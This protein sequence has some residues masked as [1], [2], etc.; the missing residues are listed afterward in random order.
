MN[1]KDFIIKSTFSAIGITSLSGFTE[2][3]ENPYK[4]KLIQY[5]NRNLNEAGFRYIFPK[6]Q[7][8][9]SFPLPEGMRV[10][11]GWSSF[12]VP[13]LGLGESPILK[14]NDMV[15][16]EDTCSLRFSIALD[17]REEKQIE[18][19]LAES[20]TIVACFNVK[21]APVHQIQSVFIEAKYIPA[22]LDQGVRLQMKKGDSPL[23]I[24][25]PSATQQN[26]IKALQP[27]IMIPG[28]ANPLNAFFD[29]LFSIDSIQQFGWMEGC[30]TD[31]LW[32]FSLLP[33]Y[34]ER[35]KQSLI[36][37]FE[38]FLINNNLVYENPRSKI[39]DNTIYGDECTL[40]FAAMARLYPDHPSIGLAINYWL[41]RYAKGI[42]EAES[43]QLTTEGSY[44]IGYPMMVIGNQRK[45]DQLVDLALSILRSRRNILKQKDAIYQI[46]YRDNQRAFRNW[47]RG[48]A[49]YMLGLTRS[50][51]ILQPED[52]PADLLSDLRD[53][54]DWVI[55]HQLEGGLWRC[56]LD[57]RG[58]RI[59]T[60]GSA[61]IA[62]ALAL[63]VKSGML[64]SNARD[65]AI[66]TS[67]ALMDY[68]TDDGLLTSA[69]QSNRSGERLQ[70]D[71]YRVIYQMGMGLM[72]QLIAALD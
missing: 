11:F 16:V 70:R 61:G 33:K 35:A 9:Q 55:S 3:S 15:M 6:V 66:K 37:H 42:T 54:A 4:T 38:K 21:Y 23:W 25:S 17:V 48:I 18:V 53:T 67:L 8:A 34:A 49:W 46:R 65:S 43:Y 27:H 41:T 62:A 45:D 36:D 60:S 57:E 51:M 68:L 30:V 31:A 69:A 50:L 63:G 24:I 39:A 71:D 12:V 10:P 2:A 7:S 13:P 26:N 64:S 58:I 28:D 32:D 59:D 44:T 56:F 47:A 20:E 22:I 72:G 1:R 5:S 14:W 29:R 52:R 40:P 19:R